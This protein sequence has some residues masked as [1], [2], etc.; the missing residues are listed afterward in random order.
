[1]E[2][3][4]KF[5]HRGMGVWNRCLSFATGCGGMESLLKFCHRGM[6]VWNRCLSFATGCGY[7]KKI[8]FLPGKVLSF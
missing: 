8:Q 3:L 6:G 1:M 4:L 5:C 2:S 7:G